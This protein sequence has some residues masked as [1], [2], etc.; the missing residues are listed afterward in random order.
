M[1][2]NDP[3]RSEAEYLERGVANLRKFD[4]SPI[5]E[6]VADRR[7]VEDAEALE[8]K[9]KRLAK[10]ALERRGPDDDPNEIVVPSDDLR[11][12]WEEFTRD[13]ER[14]ERFCDCVFGYHWAHQPGTYWSHEPSGGPDEEV[15]AATDPVDVRFTE[16]E[17]DAERDRIVE[18][19][20]DEVRRDVIIA[21]TEHE[22]D[23][24]I[25][26]ISGGVDSALVAALAVEALGPDNVY[27]LLMPSE[28][29]GD[30]EASDAERLATDLGIEYDIVEMD[31][32]LERVHAGFEHTTAAERLIEKVDER[33]GVVES[34]LRFLAQ[35][36]LR[37]TILRLCV[38]GTEGVVVGTTNRTEWLTGFFDPHGDGA[39][40]CQPIIHLYKRQVRQLARHVGVPE[41]IASRPAR[42][43]ETAGNDEE[44]LG[45][46][47]D[48]L[49][50]VLALHIDGD[51][52]VGRTASMLGV[53]TEVV[54]HVADLYQSTEN[55]RTYPPSLT[56]L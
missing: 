46:E 42:E 8:K 9:F 20:R 45:I 10:E 33:P 35:V 43:T 53:E 40:Q 6:R 7:D 38:P 22:H 4:L 36:R 25:V 24:A 3:S 16:A 44:T 18:F 54:E 37:S 55:R 31:P 30:D 32:I 27:G 2:P 13:T 5:T 14:Y 11:E 52:S 23:T 39:V 51:L 34:T 50:A 41:S 48:T 47:F 29:T 56:S 28:D 21:G 26:G 1:N 17:L 49:D 12:Y 15:F 19:I